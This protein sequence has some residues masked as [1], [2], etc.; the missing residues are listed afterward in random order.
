VLTCADVLITSVR[1]SALRRLGLADAHVTYP[2]LSHV[3]IVGH[4]GDL[5]EVPGHDLTYQAAYGTLDPPSMPPAPVEL[6]AS[7]SKMQPPSRARR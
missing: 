3:E 6:T 5:E 4:D 7:S 1:P 2:G